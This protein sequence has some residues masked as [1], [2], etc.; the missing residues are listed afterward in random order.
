MRYNSP[1]TKLLKEAVA[2]L[3]TLPDVEQDR[4]AHALFAFTREL[5]ESADEAATV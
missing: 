5:A 3:G 1:M 2:L 4:L